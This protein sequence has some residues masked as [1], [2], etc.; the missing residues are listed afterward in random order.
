[1]GEPA[2]SN[3]GDK[4]IY[5]EASANYGRQFAAKHNLGAMLLYYQKARQLHNEAL[6]FK[7]QAYVGRVTYMYEDR[8]SMEAN[9]GF[10]GSET[11][12]EGNRFGFFPA[13]GLAWIASNEPYFPESLKHSINSLKFRVSRGR[14]GNDNTGGARFLYRPTYATSTGYPFGIGG[15][16]V[17]NNLGGRIEGRFAAPELAWEIEDKRNY[18]IDLSMFNGRIDLTADYFDNYRTNILLQRRTVSEAAGFRQAPWQNF[19]EVSNKGLDASLDLR[20]SFSQDLTV[21]L[22]GNLTYA[23]NKIIEYD[24]VPQLYPWMNTTGNRLRMYNL[25]VAEGLY[26][27]DDFII[28]G[29]GNARTYELKPGLATSSMSSTLRPGDIKYA[30]L[31][32]DGVI[33]QFDQ[34]RYEG[35]P[36]VPELIYGA[37]LNVSYK[38]VYASVFFQGADK[39]STVLGG[40]ESQSFFPFQWGV[41][42]TSV[43][44]EALNRWTEENPAQDVMFPRL[45]SGDYPHNRTPSTWW[46]RDASFLRLKNVELGYQ[47]QANGLK[48]I[49]FK[50]ARA[51]LMGQN[52][53]VWDKIKMW[54]PEMGNEN[55]GMKYPLPKIWSFGL[56]LTL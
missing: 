11:F 16:G 34:T 5:L 30:D 15:S 25:Y 22:R 8:Y 23:R 6:A 18:G 53:A 2:E 21:S 38:G 55:A 9:F 4:R 27:Q 54:D 40:Q 19:G 32:G 13:I 33:N 56:E 20:H 42:E 12:A 1:M 52:I 48:K 50:A 41:D 44:T 49:G 35:N 51:Y 10:T 37:G 17:L 7:K 45:R 28:T 47:L 29:T 46:L 24:E 14:T 31:N 36:S 3:A 43:R 39:V 26:T